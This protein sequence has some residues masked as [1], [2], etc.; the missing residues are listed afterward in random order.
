[1]N[2]FMYL[3]RLT[4][5]LTIGLLFIAGCS[6]AIEVSKPPIKDIKELGPNQTIVVGRFVLEPPLE[7]TKYRGT[8]IDYVM[9]GVYEKYPPKGKMAL[10]YSDILYNDIKGQSY[11]GGRIEK[12]IF[13]KSTN[14]SFYL[15]GCNFGRIEFPARFRVNISP[16]DKAIYIGTIIYYRDDFNGFKK[17]KIKNEYKKAKKAFQKKFGKSLKLRKSLLTPIE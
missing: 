10:S 7:V 15:V 5:M 3:M 14:R 9:V 13:V 1:M 12:F 16:D 8:N 2:R 17:F 4:V 11:F 6:S